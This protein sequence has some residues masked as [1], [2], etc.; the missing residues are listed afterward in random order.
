MSPCCL[1]FSVVGWTNVLLYLNHR[2]LT[3]ALKR[4]LTK[5]QKQIEIDSVS[6]FVVED[7]AAFSDDEGAWCAAASGGA[8]AATFDRDPDSPA[9]RFFSIC[10]GVPWPLLWLPH[11]RPNFFRHGSDP[12]GSYRFFVCVSS[13]IVL[14]QLSSWFSVR[15]IHSEWWCRCKSWRFSYLCFACLNW[16]FIAT[17]LVNYW[18]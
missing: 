13:F 14:Y 12:T 16:K 9:P 17:L 15:E 5:K 8:E 2:I 3:R 1:H 6:F 11:R 7:S 4:D 10:V 18:A